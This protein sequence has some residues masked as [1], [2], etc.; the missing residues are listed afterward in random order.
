MSNAAGAL[1]GIKALERESEAAHQ[2]VADALEGA[3]VLLHGA[4]VS[5]Y[6]LTYQITGLRAYRGIV[7]AYGVR[8]YGSKAKKPNGVREYDLHEFNGCKV[9]KYP[10]QGDARQPTSSPTTIPVNQ[11]SHP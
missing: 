1:E 7:R 6:G 4:I 3:R 8:W 2:R 11:G 5:K 10:D 9:L